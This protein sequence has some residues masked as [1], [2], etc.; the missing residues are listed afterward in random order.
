MGCNLGLFISEFLPHN[1]PMKKKKPSK[2]LSTK[3]AIK[4]Q[5]METGR[6]S[7]CSV[8]SCT[9][10][11]P[12]PALQAALDEIARLQAEQRE[13]ERLEQMLLARQ[14]KDSR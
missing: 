9:G 7:L 2:S 12:C 5:V 14:R 11:C 4:P 8:Q 1:V 10:P 3:T 13:L 6:S